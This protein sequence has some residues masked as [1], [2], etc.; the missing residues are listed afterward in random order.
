MNYLRNLRLVVQQTGNR[1]GT[2]FVKSYLSSLALTGSL[3]DSRTETIRVF[4]AHLVP[5]FTYAVFKD[6]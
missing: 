3:A 6:I 2:R 1:N 4:C 5:G